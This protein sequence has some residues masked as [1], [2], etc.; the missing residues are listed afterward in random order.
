LFSDGTA[1]IHWVFRI[2][3]WKMISMKATLSPRVF[4]FSCSFEV[5][6]NKQRTGTILLTN[7]W[8]MNRDVD[9]YGPDAELFKPERHLDENGQLKSIC[10]ATKDD[11]HVNF[12]FGRR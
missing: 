10:S 9:V 4:P 3:V 8:S 12:G 11:G 7:I 5:V 1:S 2:R 6:L